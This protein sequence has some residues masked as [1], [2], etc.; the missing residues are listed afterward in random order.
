ML[1]RLGCAPRL[2]GHDCTRW[3]LAA[4]RDEF[5]WLQGRSLAGI[6]R[7]LQHLGIARKWSQSHIHSPDPNYLAKQAALRTALTVARQDPATV[8]CLLDEVTLARQPSNA[9]VYAARGRRQPRARRSHRS[10]TTHRVIAALNVRTGQ[11]Q[12]RQRSTLTVATL[13]DFFRDLVA[14]Y[15]GRPIVV[16]LDNWPVHFHP[17]LL[18]A[19]VPQTTPFPF[20][21][22]RHWPTAPRPAAVAQWGHLNLPIQFLPLP[23]YASW[24]N[25]IE[26]LWRWLRQTVVHRHPWADALPTL[27]QAVAAFLNRFATGSPEL[28]RY[29]GLA[30]PD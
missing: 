13:V 6:S 22:P 3:T 16:V 18:A 27:W 12:W 17:D 9:P 24:L 7:L 10:E 21:R 20:P 8:V 25:P 30:P 2:R 29:V 19:L 1:G 11:V 5:P 23:T 26:K 14:A 15:D 28:L 4:I